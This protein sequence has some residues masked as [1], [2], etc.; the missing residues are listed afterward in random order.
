MN[1]KYFIFRGSEFQFCDKSGTYGKCTD[2]QDVKDQCGTSQVPKNCSQYCAG[3]KN[4]IIFEDF[5]TFLLGQSQAPSP[6][7]AF[8]NL[9]M[10]CNIDV[11]FTLFMCCVFNSKNTSFKVLYRSFVSICFYNIFK[12]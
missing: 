5:I 8:G 12:Q 2:C 4:K 3:K 1:V 10:Q 7:F 11:V 9:N 6:S